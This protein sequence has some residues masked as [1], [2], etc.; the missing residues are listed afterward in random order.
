MGRISCHVS[1]GK[2]IGIRQVIGQKRGE[3]THPAIFL[4]ARQTGSGR[5]GDGGMPS[6]RLSL[7]E[8]DRQ[9]AD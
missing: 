6:C 8:E 1:Q 3:E 4:K 2:A 7:G 9:W 5:S